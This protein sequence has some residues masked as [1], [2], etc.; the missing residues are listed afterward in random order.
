MMNLIFLVLASPILGLV[1]S[2]SL[3]GEG[4]QFCEPSALRRGFP[5]R[6]YKHAGVGDE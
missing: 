4:R 2:T 5:P 1:V 6:S 3:S